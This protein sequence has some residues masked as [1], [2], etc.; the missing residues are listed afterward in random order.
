MFLMLSQYVSLLNNELEKIQVTILNII[1]DIHH[2]KFSTLLLGPNQVAA[3]LEDLVQIIPEGLQAPSLTQLYKL[4]TIKSKI[5]KTSVIF[6]LYIPLIKSTEFEV[7]KMIPFPQLING[8]F[9]SIETSN[10][11]F[12]TNLHRD[13]A[14]TLSDIEWRDCISVSSEN[15]SCEQ[16]RP[17]YTKETKEVEC[18]FN[19][20]AQQTIADKCNI[21]LTKSNK[22]WVQLTR[23]NSW[24]Y[25]LDKEYLFNTVCDGL[26]YQQRLKGTGLL[27]FHE[28]CLLKDNGVVIQTFQISSSEYRKVS[29]SI[30]MPQLQK[31]LES[32]LFSS[33]HINSLNLTDTFSAKYGK[34]KQQLQALKKQEN[35]FQAMSYHDKH[36]YIVS[37]SAIVVSALIISMYISKKYI[38]NK[39]HK[40]VEQPQHI[41]LRTQD[42]QI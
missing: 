13:T 37:Y 1:H 20:I 21:K 25:S 9:C 39:N 6:V 15:F 11:L 18:E 10:E 24:P 22:Y 5:T 28:I 26:V 17:L 35:S 2:D 12:W 31:E 32:S 23:K 14:Y 36:Q 33:V 16:L 4:T 27:N 7:Y 34:I 8:T 42:F 40:L 29:P 3:Y 19:L 38:F 41:Q 30:N